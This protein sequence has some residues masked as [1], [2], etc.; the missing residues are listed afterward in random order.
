MECIETVKEAL[1]YA[2][3]RKVLFRYPE[4][5]TNGFLVGNDEVIVWM[6]NY[7]NMPNETNAWSTVN[8]T[9]GML[10]ALVDT[11]KCLIERLEG[12]GIWCVLSGDYGVGV[13]ADGSLYIT[14][15]G[16]ELKEDEET[17]EGPI[18]KELK[19]KGWEVV[20]VAYGSELHHMWLGI[21]G[22]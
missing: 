5:S 4:H 16:V 1:S 11:V 2:Q 8:V 21:V 3:D 17:K 12:D 7:M 19:N 18:F 14:F 6:R 13:L 22:D 10:E 15:Q 20:N 9:I